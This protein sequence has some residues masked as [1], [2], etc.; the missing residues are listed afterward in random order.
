MLHSTMAKQT[1]QKDKQ[2]WTIHRKLHIEKD[3]PTENRGG[4]GGELE[5]SRRVSSSC[6]S[7][8][9]RRVTLATHLLTTTK[10]NIS[11]VMWD[12]DVL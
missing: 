9:T 3:N 7:N 10:Q 8:N 11:V 1:G 2:W 5:C 6:S 4:N 12:I